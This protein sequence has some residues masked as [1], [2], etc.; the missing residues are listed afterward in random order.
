MSP[1]ET[2]G[3]LIGDVAVLQG[4][5]TRQ[6]SPEEVERAI[7]ICDRV[8]PAMQVIRN[9]LLVNN[10]VSGEYNLAEGQI[11]CHKHEPMSA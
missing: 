2:A 10:G 5:L 4:Y 3:L 8:V 9:A 1:N 6:L 11:K 7:S